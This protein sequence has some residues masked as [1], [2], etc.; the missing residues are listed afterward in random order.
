VGN[1]TLGQIKSASDVLTQ[2]GWETVLVVC[3]NNSRDR[4]AEIARAAGATVVFEPVN[5]IARA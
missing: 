3:D 2:S 5:Q 4:T 1:P